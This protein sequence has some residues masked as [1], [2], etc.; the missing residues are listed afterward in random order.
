[1]ADERLETWYVKVSFGAEWGPMSSDTLLEM[2]DNG[3]LARDDMARCD[4]AADWQPI[5][6]VIDQLRPAPLPPASSPT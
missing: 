3:D 5:Q 1:M 4:E 2:A 6:T